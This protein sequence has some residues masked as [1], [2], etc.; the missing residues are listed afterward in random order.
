[1]AIPNVIRCWDSEATD[2]VMTFADPSAS[3]VGSAHWGDGCGIRKRL[4][5][6]SWGNNIVLIAHSYIAQQSTGTL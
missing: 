3:L 2:G 1:M 5:A 6:A 4:R